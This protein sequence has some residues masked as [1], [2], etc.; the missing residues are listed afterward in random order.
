MIIISILMK[1]MINKLFSSYYN[2]NI[3]ST[4]FICAFE[5][6]DSA[7]FLI[8]ELKSPTCEARIH[9][10]FVQ[11]S[12]SFADTDN[13]KFSSSSS[14]SFSKSSIKTTI[15]SSI[16]ETPVT[17]LIRI[18]KRDPGGYQYV[19]EGEFVTFSKVTLECKFH[20]NHPINYYNYKAENKKELFTDPLLTEFSYGHS[21]SG[22]W[23]PLDNKLYVSYQTGM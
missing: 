17:R 11:T 19:N 23:D 20:Q 21:I 4:H 2:L 7:Y 9:N 1:S 14:S 12:S 13:V 22:K 16:T 8:R 3:E 6:S 10:R 5:T 18:C 15:L